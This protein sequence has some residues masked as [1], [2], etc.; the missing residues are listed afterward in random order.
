MAESS[1]ENSINESSVILMQSLTIRTL[2]A[3][4]AL[5]FSTVVASAATSPNPDKAYP[6]TAALS[7]HPQRVL[8]S[9]RNVSGQHRDVVIGNQRFSVSPFD[10]LTLSVAVGSA[11]YER[12]DMNSKVD[13]KQLLVA[14]SGVNRHTILLP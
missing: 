10:N 11:I 3:V 6:R 2:L 7:K 14:S 12:S 13:G 4:A 5:S 9:F 1:A 8:V